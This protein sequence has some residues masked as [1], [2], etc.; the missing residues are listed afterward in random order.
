MEAD[1]TKRLD[2]ISFV[3]QDRELESV[4]C[5]CRCGGP[6][7]GSSERLYAADRAVR[8]GHSERILPG[9][10]RVYR[11]ESDGVLRP[12]LHCLLDLVRAALG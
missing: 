1:P 6:V 8:M 9:L 7:A 3:W 2:L 12:G 11:S 10:K 4:D 5:S